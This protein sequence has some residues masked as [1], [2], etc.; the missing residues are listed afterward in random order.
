MGFFYQSHP[1]LYLQS[2]CKI[3][4]AITGCVLFLLIVESLYSS[5]YGKYFLLDYIFSRFSRK[6]NKISMQAS[7]HN[8]QCN[9]INVCS[10]EDDWKADSEQV[11]V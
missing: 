11:Y 10:L 9:F 2:W 8:D 7:H 6:I 4:L 3:T 1:K 5:V